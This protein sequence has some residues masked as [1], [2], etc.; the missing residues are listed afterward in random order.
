ML[1]N[2]EKN[3]VPGI[4]MALFATFGAAGLGLSTVLSNR[5]PLIVGLVLGIYLLFSIKV[6]DQW[7]KVAVLATLGCAV[8]VG[9]TCSRS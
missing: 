5:L 7:E 8:R 9:F 4:A 2:S 6:A 3:Q 1:W